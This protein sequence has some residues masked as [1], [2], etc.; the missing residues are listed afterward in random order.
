MAGGVSL[1]VSRRMGEIRQQAPLPKKAAPVSTK[2]AARRLRAPLMPPTPGAKY[3][4]NPNRAWG[5]TRLEEAFQC[6]PDGM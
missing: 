3:F 2:E 6:R 1:A 5:V 4:R